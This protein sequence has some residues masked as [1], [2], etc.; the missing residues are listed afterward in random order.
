MKRLP[1]GLILLSGEIE[2]PR[3]SDINYPFRQ[4]SNFIYLTGVQDPDFHV[5]LDPRS[6]RSTLFIP[7]IDAEHKV[8]LGPIP[9]PAQC[10]KLY[11]FSR[12]AYADELPAHFRKARK[13][14][15]R[16]YANPAAAKT[17]PKLASFK[18]K[19]TDT[20]LDALEELRALKSDGELGFIRA[21]SRTAEQ[22]H[23][24][25]MLRALPG[26]R[27]YEVQALFDGE[28]LRRGLKHLAFPSIVAAGANSAILHYVRN[29]ALLRKGQLVLLDAGAECLGYAS[30]ITRTFPVD[31]HFSQRQRDVYSIVLEAQKA[32]IRQVRAGAL[33]TDLHRL[34][35]TVI[36]EGLKSLG[37]LKGDACGLVEN[38]AVKLFYP[39]GIGHLMGLDVHDGRGGKKRHMENPGKVP[40]RFVAKLEAGFVLTVEPGIY[41]ID[42]LLM[43]PAQRAKHK[44]SVDFSK[45]ERFLD[46]G[47]V[48]IEDDL[49]VRKNGY[50]NLTD[51]RVC[52]KEIPQIEEL[53]AQA[54]A[55]AG[56]KARV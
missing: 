24:S 50:E 55:Q 39:H 22:A 1:D 56:R 2:T 42:A 34:S 18:K 17:F 15:R 31:R 41:F 37:I 20:L 5:L 28:C 45:A 48:R 49:L 6:G 13:G 47:G 14:S 43:D 27:E 29:D 16:C 3:N 33:S 12:I 35:M 11:G 19:D 46:F 36:A 52:P 40:I 44:G 4:N 9:G 30:D 7:R 26:M 21:A 32:C 54:F 8:W 51:S 23:R 53:R 25:A 38:G 10:R